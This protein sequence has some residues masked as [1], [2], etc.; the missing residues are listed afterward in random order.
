MQPTTP[1]P[2]TPTKSG[3]FKPENTTF[4]DKQKSDL[5]A[6]TAL[7]VS[8]NA[9]LRDAPSKSSNIIGVV[10]QENMVVLLDRESKDGWYNVIDIETSKEGWLH[11]S[12]LKITLAKNPKQEQLFQAETLSYFTEPEIAVQNAS[13]LNIN[14]KIGNQLIVIPAN[15]NKSLKISQGTYK[16][17][18]T[19]PGVFPSLGTQTFNNSNIYSWKFWVVTSRG[20][21]GKR[22]QR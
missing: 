9:N 16:Y 8:Q 6:D 13:Y 5:N 21:R 15:S 4:D 14:L 20:T 10:I 11:Q 2:S 17:Y 12:T 19:A 1:V 18:A 7:I 22:G 3:N